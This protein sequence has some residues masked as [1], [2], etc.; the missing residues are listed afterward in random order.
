MD[1]RVPAEVFA[2]GEFLAEEREA[3]GWSQIDLAEI[4]GRPP[5]LIS[6]LVTGKRG[7]T[8]ET[9]LGLGA[10]FE[11]SAHYWMNLETAY[12]L[13]KAQSIEP[14]VSRRARLY[15]IFPVKELLKRGWIQGSN[16]VAVMEQR[17][18]AFFG[19]ASMSERP[20]FA[21]AAKSTTYENSM[22]KL[23]W[24]NRAKQVA[25]AVP[26]SKFSVA[27]IR[28]A[29][30]ALRRCME[31]KEEI[32]NVASILAGAG[33]RIVIVEHLPRDKMDGVCFWLDSG[34]VIALSLR[35]DRIENF[36]FNIFH[37]IDQ[38]IY[39]AGK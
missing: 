14:A 30:P 1:E 15:E 2:P 39:R 4:L 16:N 32:K 33:V 7:V 13:S 6:E 28:G 10:A 34:P 29:I 35:F 27:A 25:K 12:Q 3:R 24:L 8:P 21:H 38:R 37:E 20:R 5:R 9:A 17:F 22:I 19:M 23:A 31:Y 36:W 18:L 11:T 26:A